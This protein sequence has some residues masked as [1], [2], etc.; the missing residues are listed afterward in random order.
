MQG[1]HHFE[2][3]DITIRYKSKLNNTYTFSFLDIL[4]SCR[5]KEIFFLNIIIECYIKT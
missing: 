5:C 2:L 4:A 3:P 1:E